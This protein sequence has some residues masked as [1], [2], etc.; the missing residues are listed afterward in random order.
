[1]S[2]AYAACGVPQPR[3]RGATVFDGGS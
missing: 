1:M 3:A 2:K